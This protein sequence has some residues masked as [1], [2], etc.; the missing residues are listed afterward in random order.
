MPHRQ[1]QAGHYLF[2]LFIFFSHSLF[3]SLQKMELVIRLNVNVQKI[4][5]KIEKKNLE[6]L[7]K[8]G[9]QLPPILK[10]LNHLL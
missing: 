4:N 3:L 9:Q 7:P 6:H 1:Q 2:S 10:I 8:N 5:L